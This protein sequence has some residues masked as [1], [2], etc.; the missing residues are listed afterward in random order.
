MRTHHLLAASLIIALIAGCSS[1]N[2]TTAPPSDDDVHRGDDG[3]NTNE[4]AAFATNLIVNETKNDNQP[5]LTENRTFTDK[6]DRSA[7]PP[8]FFR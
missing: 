3:P 2:A 1:D 4:F 5:T 8:A 6:E 7:F